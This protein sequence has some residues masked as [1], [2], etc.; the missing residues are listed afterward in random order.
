MNSYNRM[1]VALDLSNKDQQLIQYAEILTDFFKIPKVYFVHILPD[2]NSPLNFLTKFY[3][4][5]DPAKPVDEIIKNHIE[6]KVDERFNHME[7]VEVKVEIIEGKPYQKLI[8][9]IDVKKIDLMVIG[10]KINGK[11]SGLTPKRIAR[12]GKSDICLVADRP[13]L[14]IKKILVPLDFSSHSASALRMALNFKEKDPSVEVVGIHI[15]VT[16]AITPIAGVVY[17]NH[18]AVFLKQRAKNNFQKLLINNGIDQSRVQFEIVISENTNIGRTLSELGKEENFD[19]IITSAIGH[20]AFEG[21]FL[22]SVTESM[23]HYN[24]E[25][26]VLIIR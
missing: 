7:D 8:H 11:G 2:F 25:V 15:A 9:W 4:S 1:L 20:T 17:V 26:P 19:L 14:P 24:S 12:K 22:G 13:G 16:M 21:F 3:K 6:S 10:N 23:V 18:D 5:S